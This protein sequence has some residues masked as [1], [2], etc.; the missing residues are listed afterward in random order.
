MPQLESIKDLLPCGPKPLDQQS[1]QYDAHTSYRSRSTIMPNQQMTRG[2][3]GSSAGVRGGGGGTCAKSQPDDSSDQVQCYRYTPDLRTV[4][5]CRI[6]SRQVGQ[7]KSGTR[8]CPNHCTQVSATIR[9]PSW[10]GQRGEI[11]SSQHALPRAAAPDGPPDTTLRMYADDR[12]AA[13]RIR[14]GVH[15]GGRRGPPRPRCRS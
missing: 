2:K 3:K 12:T 1:R 8:D 10:N 13:L 7:W 9:I 6:V 5:C 15:G 11:A 14:M 4:E